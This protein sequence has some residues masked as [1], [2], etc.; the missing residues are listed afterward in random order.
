MQLGAFSI[1]LS[2]KDLNA[3]EAFYNKLGFTQFGGHKDQNWLI[4]K[5]GDTLIGLF[6]N[7]FPGNILTFNP[8]WDSNAEILEDYTDIRDLQKQLK[9]NGMEFSTE[10][11]PEGEGPASFT[12]ADPDGNTI[13]I[14]QHIG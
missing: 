10:A 11:D 1:S 4:L 7:M 3:S 5:N 9:A 6:Q 13:L 8:G 12:L 14:D 2:V